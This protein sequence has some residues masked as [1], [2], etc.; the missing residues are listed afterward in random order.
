MS[1]NDFYK[2]LFFR[3]FIKVSFFNKLLG[4][5]N[6]IMPSA[7]I[8]ENTVLGKYIYVGYNTF[9]TKSNIGNYTSIANNVSIGLGEHDGK[10]ISTNSIFYENAYEELTK[11][12][13]IIGNDVWIGV[14]VVIRRGVTIGNGAIIGANSFVN[15]DVPDYAIVAGS[16]ARIIR[17]RFSKENIK[18]IN[19]SNW[20]NLNFLDASTVI[21]KLEKIM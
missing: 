3:F 11:K 14:D 4:S 9:I 10:K 7:H 13:V 6:V 5:N 8:D 19:K 17:F 21:K 20:W 12:K 18:L 2:L 15:E 16:P 1:I